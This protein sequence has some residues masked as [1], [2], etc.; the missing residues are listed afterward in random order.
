MATVSKL[1]LKLGRLN[2]LMCVQFVLLLY[3]IQLISLH[4]ALLPNRFHI[5]VT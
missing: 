3:V 4:V 1:K 2:K 5:F